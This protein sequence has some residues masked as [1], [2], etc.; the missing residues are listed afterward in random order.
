[1]V[2][3]FMSPIWEELNLN[4]TESA[5]E[6]PTARNAY[7]PSRSIRGLYLCCAAVTTSTPSMWS[8]FLPRR[9]SMM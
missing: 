5:I 7:I 2:R 6:P 9:H 8:C 4:S 1:M 3:S